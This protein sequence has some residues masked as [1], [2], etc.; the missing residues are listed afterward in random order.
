[1]NGWDNSMAGMQR[2]HATRSLCLRQLWIWVFGIAAPPCYV[3]NCMWNGG[4]YQKAVCNS[5][6]IV[7]MSQLY[8]REKIQ[9]GGNNPWE[10]PKQVFRSWPNGLDAVAFIVCN[11]KWR[12][13][14]SLR[15]YCKGSRKSLVKPCCITVFWSSLLWAG[16]LAK[17]GEQNFPRL[18]WKC[19]KQT[20]K[21]CFSQ[22]TPTQEWWFRICWVLSFY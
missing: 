12:T 8:P 4:K 18:D 19:V 9:M 16:C 5:S 10:Y 14:P 1:M 22:V 6:W 13:C 17:L 15:E 7:G 20:R 3:L 11:T 2:T 21:K